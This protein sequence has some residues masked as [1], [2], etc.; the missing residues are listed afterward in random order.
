MRIGVDKFYPPQVDTPRFLFRERIVHDLVLRC[1]ARKPLL[2]VEAQAGQGKTTI[3]KQ[4][5]DHLGTDA[6]WYQ[7]TQE[8]AD[9][10]FFL[11]ALALC[12]ANKFPNYPLTPD[13]E[14]PSGNLARVDLPSRLDQLLRPLGDILADDLY[15]VFDDLH[16]LSAHSVSLGIIGYLIERAPSH[17]HCILSSR[18][19]LDLDALAALGPRDLIVLGNRELML[20]NDEVADLFDQ[21]FGI[22]LSHETI[23]EISLKTDGWIMGALLVGLQMTAQ[24]RQMPDRNGPT[25]KDMREYFR[26][27]VFAPLEPA[28]HG[29]LLQLSLLEDIPVALARTLTGVPEIGVALD[30]LARRNVFIRRLDPA[31]TIF[32]LHHL[33]RQ[34]LREKAEAE[35]AVEHIRRIHQQAGAYFLDRDNPTKALRAYVRAKDYD[36][37]ETTLRRCG[38]TMLAA[39]QTATLATILGA[40]PAPA[41]AGHGWTALT[42]ALALLDFAPA[43]ALP[44]LS[45][46]LEVFSRSGDALGEL[47]CLAHSIAIHI[48]TTGHYR[49]GADLLARAEAIFTQTA[50]QLDVCTT[51]LVARSLAM[52]HSIF[53]ADAEGAI[54]YAE[55][56]L[57]LA[58]RENC[59]NFE[60][61]LLM[62]I[63]YIRIFAG[64]LALAR[65]WLEQ[66]A[67]LLER[68]GVGSFNA[69]AIRMMCFNF[70]FHDG[71]FA[72]YHEQKNRMVATI[73]QVLFSQSIAG[74]FC[75]VW[76]MDIALNEGRFEDVLDMAAAALAQRPPLR[77][78]LASQVLQL[79]AVALA[80][81]GQ[82]EAALDLLARSRHLRELAGGP[83]FLA[84]HALIEGLVRACCGDGEA[85]LAQ[86]TEGIDRARRMP[87]A[88]LESGGLLHRA[89]V[90]LGRGD[91][92]RAA[93]DLTRGL[94]L[95]RRNGYRH[96]WVWLPEAIRTALGFAV[97]RGIEL[98]Y[99]RALAAQRLD[100]AIRDD[101]MPIPHLV[102]RILGGFTLLRQGAV[103]LEAEALTPAQ[104]ELLCLLIASPDLKMAQE[105]AQLH[106]WPDSPAGAAKTSFDTMLSRLRKALAGALPENTAQHYLSRD[107][108]IVW[109]QHCRVDAHDFLDAVHQGLGHWRLGERWQ[110]GN[111]FTRAEAL[112]RGEFAPGVTGEDRVRVFREGLVEALHQ[113]ALVW[114]DHLAESDRTQQ[115][116]RLAEKAV[117]ADP[118]NDAPWGLLYRLRGR[119]SAIAARQVL[120]R[121]AK[122]LRDDDYTEEEIAAILDGIVTSAAKVAIPAH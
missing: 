64:E 83:Y 72:N 119:R 70:L 6:A 10:A 86:L 42:L 82:P 5:L 88:Y 53:L 24:H 118:L 36:A 29:P 76:E 91:Q 28:L 122:R 121:F 30:G 52:G 45:Q 67:D 50:D 12:L 75:H 7:V 59:V 110:A 1:G 20:R 109:L 94:G 46:A 79:Q 97:A 68:P 62:V 74:P 77:P 33:F 100:A 116:L 104:R 47:L 80:K 95:M 31:G 16:L 2:V 113:M 23:Q 114:C 15:L 69:L 18:E 78:H 66:A 35:L 48:T 93:T 117:A 85:A 27:K 108:G 103:V 96:F 115:A 13:I 89:A 57:E 21:V 92:E 44:L 4:F 60:A 99:A 84:L 81:T 90:H 54:G 63:G 43:R 98:G 71:D 105:T 73:G 101:G 32:G 11:T 56:A 3:I 9:P 39:N 55:P 106:F 111:A 40:L 37:I 120:T 49:E 112:W 58:R 14:P 38:T 41:L 87:S 65:P 22:T 19:P 26:G 107:K 17:L 51:I 34:F 61:V 102:F 25:G 8:D